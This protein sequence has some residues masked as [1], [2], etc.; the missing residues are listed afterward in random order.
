[1]AV[2]SSVPPLTLSKP[3]L[4]ILIPISILVPMPGSWLQGWLLPNTI[5]IK[6]N[7]F[8]PNYFAP[9]AEQPSPGELHSFAPLLPPTASGNQSHLPHSQLSTTSRRFQAWGGSKAKLWHII[10]PGEAVGNRSAR[11]PTPQ[12]HLP[13]Q[14]WSD[15]SWILHSLLLSA[16]APVQPHPGSKNTGL[17]FPPQ[18]PKLFMSAAP[19]QTI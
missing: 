14:T 6:K 15:C 13:T 2:S 1:M 10:L 4:C 3:Q 18:I 5:Q 17:R 12:Q 9:L 11:L 16:G 19:C 7:H 8:W